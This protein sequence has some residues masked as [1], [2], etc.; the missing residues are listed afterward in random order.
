MTPSPRETARALSGT[1]R[2][3]HVAHFL[4]PDWARVAQLTLPAVERLAPEG[5]GTQLLLLVPDAGAAT[6][7]ARALARLI[8]PDAAAPRV[9]A[10]TTPARARRLLAAGPAPVVIGSPAVIADVLATS[11]ASLGG[12]TTVGFVAADELDAEDPALATVLAE[13][14][15]E[16][17]R[18]LT[19]LSATPSVE[20][21]IER[22]L[23]KARRVTEDLVP[24]AAAT[25]STTDAATWVVTTVGAPEETLPM[26]LDEVDVPST[27]I[28]TDDPACAER[29]RQLIRSLGYTDPA[30]V[31]VTEG[32]LAANAAL[33][34]VLGLPTGS[35]WAA[36]T[37]AHPAQTIV[38]VPP[39][40]HLALRQVIGET[41]LLPFGAAGTIDRARTAEARVR[42]E[43]RTI[44]GTGLP[45]HEILAL[46]PLLAS[47]DGVEI[48]AAALRL[49]EQTR[50]AQNEL[51]QAAVRRV[52]DQHQQE[53]E[54]ARLAERERDP[55]GGRE[56]RDR[57]PKPGGFG[58]RGPRGGPARGE[59]PRGG[60]G[61]GGPRREGDGPRGPRSGPPRGG[62]RAPR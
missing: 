61:R 37:A 2:S 28:V 52:R 27:A 19:A 56:C 45:A 10:A 48:A 25:P 4:P 9:V 55:R 38:V 29:A 58:A 30:L 23:H 26:I 11:G 40:H 7:L 5:P 57:G 32:E 1:V 12:V 6:A 34:I 39:R 44:L 54:A 35:R 50:A 31:T 20:R 43:L 21:V 49:L 3:A 46:E 62:P 53:K 24:A 60:P 16:A 15:K 51:V 17:A 59:G 41:R 8:A 33:V 36:V 14:P 42:S 22:H 18:W 47:Y 13:V